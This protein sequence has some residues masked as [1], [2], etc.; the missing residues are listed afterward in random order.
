MIKLLRPCRQFQSKILY[1]LPLLLCFIFFRSVAQEASFTASVS[2]NRVAVGEQFQVSFSVNTNASNFNPP[3]FSEF[4]VYSG[5]NQSSSMQIINGNMSQTISLTY[6]IAAKREGKFNIGSAS[7]NAGGKVLQTRPVPIEVSKGSPPSQ[8]NAQQNNK[9]GQSGYPEDVESNIFIK[10]SPSKNKVYV[11]EQLL[12]TYKVYTRLNI[13]DNA[14]SKNPSFNGFWSEEVPNPTRQSELHTE[15]LD[16][17]QYQVAEIK[18]TILIPQ[19]A[20]SLTIDPLEM[21]VITRVKG[22]SRSNSFFDQFFGGG[23]QDVKL[24][25]AS[26]TVTIESMALPEKG[27]PAGFS[28]AVGQLSIQATIKNNQLKTDEGCNLTYTISG[29]GNL[30]L[31]EPFKLNLPSDLESFDPKI[32]DK[33]GVSTDGVKGSRTFDYLVIPRH[34]GNYK[35]EDIG[36]SYFDPQK[37][38]YI[39]LPTP[40]FE[41]NAAKGAAGESASVLRPTDKED[42]KLIGNDIRYIKTGESPLEKISSSFFGSSVFYALFA[43]PPL[44]FA[45]FLI[46]LKRQKSMRADTVGTMKR[47]AK[48]AAQKRLKLAAELLEKKQHDPFFEEI[49]KAIYGYLSHKLNLPV[50]DLNKEKITA[51]LKSRSIDHKLIDELINLLEKSEFA[52]YA[53]SKNVDSMQSSYR[54]SSDIITAL[55]NQLKK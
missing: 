37:A 14:L 54:Q 39:V 45:F 35:L 36:F 43:L 46:W 7:I 42:I 16:G 21:E 2:K 15:V 19:R 4:A 38:Q 53:P 18:R 29:K 5:P 51:V 52:R 40:E 25:I 33:I 12:V 3:D 6:I 50:S 28:G 41:I 30:K 23:Y 17:I 44:I 13:V 31:I 8:G 49:F 20:G 47:K 10:A 27:K 34:P 11:G 48:T 55:E 26:K 1:I 22:K 9:N 32:S 24:K